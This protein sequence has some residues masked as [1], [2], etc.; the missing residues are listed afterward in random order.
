MIIP[1]ISELKSVEIFSKIDSSIRFNGSKRRFH[2]ILSDFSGNPEPVDSVKKP[3]RYDPTHTYSIRL[4]PTRSDSY[5]LDP[6]HAYSSRLIPTR[7]VSYLLDP[8]HAY[9]SRL[10]PSRSVS[11][12]LDPTHTYSIRLF[13]EETFFFASS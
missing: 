9:S 12:L 11:R 2:H 10:I 1:P 5:L 7:S 4:T 8:S 3:N 6:S 13:P